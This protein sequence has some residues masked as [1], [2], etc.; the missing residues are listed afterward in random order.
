MLRC[1]AEVRVTSESPI[2]SEI[3]SITDYIGSAGPRDYW[4]TDALFAFHGLEAEN[5]ARWSGKQLPGPHSRC[6]L[7]QVGGRFALAR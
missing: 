7:C 3:S 6:V 5:I 2:A 4:S 1:A